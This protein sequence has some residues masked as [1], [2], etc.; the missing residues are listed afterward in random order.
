MNLSPW[1]Y[2]YYNKHA[3]RS[4]MHVKLK[5]PV[6]PYQSSMDY[7]NTKITQQVSVF[8]MLKLDTMRKKYCQCHCERTP[9]G[10]CHSEH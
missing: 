3:K 4:H 10:K 5:N 7:G 6:V 8:I 2:N 9:Q 1:V